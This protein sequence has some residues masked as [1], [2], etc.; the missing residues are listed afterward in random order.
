MLLTSSC[1]HK[2]YTPSVP[3]LIDVLAIICDFA[4]MDVAAY[5]PARRKKNHAQPGVKPTTNSHTPP[6]ANQLSYGNNLSRFHAQTYL[7]EIKQ[8][9]YPLINHS[10]V[11]TILS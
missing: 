1:R 6:E 10:L 7:I 2:L 8:E 4:K 5:V 9:N 11:I 3:D